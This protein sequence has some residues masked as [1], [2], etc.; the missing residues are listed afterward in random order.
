MANISYGGYS[1]SFGG[2]MPG[3]VAIAMP[4]EPT[5]KLYEILVASQVPSNPH[6]FNQGLT[7]VP[8]DYTIDRKGLFIGKLVGAACLLAVF[9]PLVIVVPL[10]MFSG[11]SS[12]TTNFPGD[13]HIKS[14]QSSISTGLIIFIVVGALMFSALATCLI[15]SAVRRPRK[16]VFSVEQRALLLEYGCKGPEVAYFD[17]LGAP[18][19]N[20]SNNHKEKHKLHFDL[21][22]P[23]LN[24]E[25][26]IAIE[27]TSIEARFKCANGVTVQTE[28]LTRDLIEI[29]AKVCHIFRYVKQVPEPLSIPLHVQFNLAELD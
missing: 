27:L 5:S 4:T 11:A 23:R 1:V 16:I 21:R 24:G 19:I 25:S 26:D 14:A 22:I 8:A 29:A 2:P 12:I 18:Y 10:L 13:P 3:Q 20:V 6:V 28:K 15:V 7:G 9:V 17:E